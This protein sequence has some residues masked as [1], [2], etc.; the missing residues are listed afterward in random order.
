MISTVKKLAK[1]PELRLLTTS[2]ATILCGVL[3]SAYVT[4][5]AV[6]DRLDWASTF[7]S[8]SFYLLCGFFLL[9]FGVQLGFLDFDRSTMRFADNEHC[10]A[11]V[12]Q[13]QLEA[14]AAQIRADPSKAGAIDI[15]ALMK[16]LGIPKG[17][18]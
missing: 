3:A 13:M 11:F 2:V 15:S 14:Y 17:K 10:L 7:S 16:Q 4:E 6:G 1:S 9:W 12:R 8:Q 18:K 5:I